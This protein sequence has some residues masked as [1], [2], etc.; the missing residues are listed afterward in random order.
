MSAE[1]HPQVAEAMLQVQQFQS[2]LEDQVHRTDTET[3]T[4]TDEAETVQVA[5]N[6]RH[7]LTGLYIENGLLRLGAET[8]GQRITE[9][10]QKVHAAATEAVAAEQQQLMASLA[11]ITDAL[12]KE[13]GRA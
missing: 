7:W 6:G 5:I 3:F 13:L 8:V 10:L 1:T 11:D 4:A 2:A 9:A 12:Q